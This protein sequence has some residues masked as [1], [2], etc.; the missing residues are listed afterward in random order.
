MFNIYGIPL[1]DEISANY[2]KYRQN[3]AVTFQ[4]ARNTV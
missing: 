2:L 1:R 4:Q 3:H